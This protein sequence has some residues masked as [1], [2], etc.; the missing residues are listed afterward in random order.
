MV[1]I[2]GSTV[3]AGGATNISFASIPQTF[4]HLQIRMFAANASAADF[5]IFFNFDTATNYIQHN[6]YGDG[7]SATTYFYGAGANAITFAFPFQGMVSSTS[8]A[9]AVMDVLDYT[10]TNKNKTTRAI[11]GIDRNGSGLV[12][13][14]SGLW[15][16]TAAIS[17][18]NVSL[19]AG[20]FVQNSRFDLYGI[21]SSQ[22]TGA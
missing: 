13:L 7:S 3:G 21:T 18:I 22:E 17:S 11:G 15:R 14:E 2:A 10:N 12:A 6:L 1:W 4:T 9:S 8:F 16:S 19:T 5:T 20:T